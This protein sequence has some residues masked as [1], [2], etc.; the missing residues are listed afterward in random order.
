V[1]ARLPP[2]LIALLASALAGCGG[3]T[4]DAAAAA[5]AAEAVAAIRAGDLPKA[6]ASADRAAAARGPAWEPWRSFLAGNAAW[7][8]CDRAESET[9]R[10]GRD[11][12]AFLRALGWARTA[13]DAWADAAA[14]GFSAPE[15]ARNVERAAIRIRR[16]EE[17]R[18][19]ADRE[20]ARPKEGGGG[21][22]GPPD[23]PE[24]PGGAPPPTPGEGGETPA[25]ETA[26][27]PA[28][29]SRAE[30]LALLERL[31]ALE[32]EKVAL[33][34]ERRALDQAGVERDW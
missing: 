22:A 21:A 26:A 4:D 16:L 2:L 24:G 15:A 6:E 23:A 25:T 28:P 8:R 1:P 13:R 5:A 14:A 3:G 30:A 11:P 18:A 31:A 27:A 9:F 32:R 12:A 20:R 7:I 17:D 19:R 34:R 33:R 10:T 29:L